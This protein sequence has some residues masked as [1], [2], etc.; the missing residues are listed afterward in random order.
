M[1]ILKSIGVFTA[2]VLSFIPGSGHAAISGLERVANGLAGPIFVTHAPNDRDRLFIVERGTPVDDNIENSTANIRILNLN[3]GMLEAIPFLSIPGID[4][5]GEG[6]FLGMAFHP[7]YQTNGKFYVYVTANDSVAGTPFSSYIRQYTV[8]EDDPDVAN[9]G[10]TPVLDFTQP[11]SNHNGGWIGFS[12]NDGYL[13]IMSGDGGGSNDSGTGHTAGTGNA[14]DTTSNLLGKVLR[15]DVDGDDFPG[16]T[17]EALAKNYAIPPTNPFK[18]GVGV[19]TDDVGDDETWAYGVR[20]PFRASFDRITH[21]LWIGDVGQGAREEIDFQ[22]ANS[23]GGE[24]YGWRLREGLIAT[25]SGGVG[26]APPSGN[27]DPVYDY[28]RDNDPFGGTVVTG[29][30]IY[31]GPDPSLQGKYFFLD[32]RNSPGTADDN[33]WNFD[34]TDPFGTVANIDGLLTPDVG[35][36]QFPVSFGEDAKGNLYIAYIATGEVYRIATDELLPGDYNA[37]GEVDDADFTEWREAF[38]TTGDSLADG[39]DDGVVDAADYVVWRR[40]FGAS[41][42]DESGA[43]GINV[44][45][46]SG[47]LVL[48]ACAGLVALAARCR[49]RART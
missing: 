49:A 33:Y 2:I 28:N 16:M 3:T 6:G 5:D 7:D 30:Y 40:N 23:D 48:G 12:P 22:P 1:R 18:E 42:H 29:G 47:A 20:N 21:D 38:G 11:Q 46:P 32:S 10:F 31:R 37:D 19:P 35:A 14:Q 41:V 43:G 9:A 26:G 4:I 27:V 15:V 45:E 17:A 36:P 25:P 13:Y 44:P 39:N 24:N 34:P 8:S